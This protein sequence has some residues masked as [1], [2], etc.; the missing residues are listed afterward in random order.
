MNL[1]RAFY[2]LVFVKNYLNLFKAGNK[3][4]CVV[5]FLS[6]GLLAF[7]VQRRLHLCFSVWKCN[8][9]ATFLGFEEKK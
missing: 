5:P 1:D 8:S 2:K 4:H 9:K 3:I 7:M 6:P